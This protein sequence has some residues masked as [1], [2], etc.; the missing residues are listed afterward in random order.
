MWWAARRFSLSLSLS[1]HRQWPQTHLQAYR[2][3][4]QNARMR[5][6]RKRGESSLLLCTKALV[7]ETRRKG[8]FVITTHKSFK[9]S[10]PVTLTSARTNLP[11]NEQF[12]FKPGERVCVFKLRAAA[13]KSLTRK[14]KLVVIHNRWQSY[15]EWPG[16]TEP[17]V[18][19]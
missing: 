9:A 2:W 4:S 11:F 5:G 6:T 7:A 19:R 15:G 8:I 18:C 17:V 10:C 3:T 12:W 16:N 14:G 13:W 1:L